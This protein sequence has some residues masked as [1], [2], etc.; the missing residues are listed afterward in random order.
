[1]GASDLVSSWGLVPCV[2][3][4]LSFGETKA[5]PL[6]PSLDAGDTSRAGATVCQEEPGLNS[7]GILG[8][9]TCARQ[10]FSHLSELW[11]FKAPLACP[12]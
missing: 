5:R 2:E 12:V 6:P 7:C 8:V 10:L 9:V 11:R 4:T 3:R 1:M